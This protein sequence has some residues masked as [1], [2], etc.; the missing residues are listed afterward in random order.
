MPSSLSTEEKSVDDLCWSTLPNHAKSV[1]L[2]V[3]A[4]VVAATDVHLTGPIGVVVVVEHAVA[5]ATVV[6]APGADNL[7]V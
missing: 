5:M 6:A 3:E 7:V 2:A 1:H 4:V